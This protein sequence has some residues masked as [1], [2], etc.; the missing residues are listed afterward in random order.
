MKDNSENAIVSAIGELGLKP[1]WI[2]NNL[3]KVETGIEKVDKNTS[4]LSYKFDRMFD[5]LKENFNL[6]EQVEN[7]KKRYSKN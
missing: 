6:K 4:D 7:R 5:F 3:E 1:D 2:E